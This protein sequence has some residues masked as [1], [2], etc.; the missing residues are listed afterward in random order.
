MRDVAFAVEHRQLQPG[1]IWPIAGSPY[2]GPDPALD[3]VHAERGCVL[4][5]GRRQPIGR[6][7]RAVETVRARPFIEELEQPPHLEI[8]KRAHV[9][10]RAGKL[11]LAVLCDA[12]ETAGKL[13]T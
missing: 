6:R 12:S 2:D 11:R 8:R 9:A 7:H 10:Q 5:A 4:D 1:I 13:Y 3:E